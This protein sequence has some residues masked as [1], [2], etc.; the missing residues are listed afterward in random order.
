MG[1]DPESCPG[2]SRRGGPFGLESGQHR[3]NHLPGPSARRR[4]KE[5]RP[6]TAQKKGAVPTRH[7]ADEG[8][9]RS[10][11][12]LTSRI[13]LA[14]EGG[15][16]SLGLLITPGQAH[17]GIMFEQVMAEVRVPRR[18]DGH[19]R[20]RPDALSADKACSCRRIRI[21]LRRRQSPTA[22]RR[23]RTR[24]ATGW[25][26][27]KRAAAHP[28]FD[29]AAYQASQRSRAHDQQPE[30]LPRRGDAL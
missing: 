27:A 17:D 10:R 13:H 21:Y 14:G 29:R 7:R 5:G 18:G 15:R 6:A 19:P 23:R 28:A 25:P 26:G 20:T 4:R 12:G 8:L 24:W 11:G 30:G 2:S 16:R 9:G 22:S 1:P 3:L